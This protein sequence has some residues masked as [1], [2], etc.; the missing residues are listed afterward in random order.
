MTSQLD[1]DS[2]GHLESQRRRLVGG[3]GGAN[4]NIIINSDDAYQ[5]LVQRFIF[6]PRFG[7]GPFSTWPQ[8]SRD[9]TNIIKPS[10]LFAIPM[11]DATWKSFLTQAVEAAQFNICFRAFLML[12]C[13]IIPTFTF[14]Y[15]FASTLGEP[16]A[17]DNSLWYNVGF[18]LG[19][20]IF[21]P[22]YL[23]CQMRWIFRPAQ[24]RV[25]RMLTDS[26]RSDDQT[27]IS[28][29]VQD[30]AEHGVKVELAEQRSDITSFCPFPSE[31]VVFLQFTRIPSSSVKHET[32]TMA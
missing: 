3:G 20:C 25:Q 19:I 27:T 4:I 23:W 29:W 21:E 11:S 14:T 8:L 30:F 24:E 7:K 26:S 1:D 6:L 18:V 28:S 17:D 15:L 22:F 32:K 12:T 31:R 10:H 13:L 9:K 16:V 2:T 5:V